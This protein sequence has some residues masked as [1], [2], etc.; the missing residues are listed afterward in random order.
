MNSRT[1]LITIIAVLLIVFCV[2]VY[3]LFFGG[4]AATSVVMPGGATGSLPNT[5][6]QSVSNSGS[7][8]STAS[9]NSTSAGAN[10]EVAINQP[11]I[12]YFASA[13]GT[14]T[15]VEPD[16]KIIQVVAGEQTVAVSSIAMQNVI[17]ASFS[18]NG[19]KVLVSFGDPADPQASVFDIRTKA[20]TPLP[21]GMLSP[22]WSPSDYRVAYTAAN[23][24]QG[25]ETIGTVNAAAVKPAATPLVTFHMQDLALAWPAK[26][27]LVLETKP[28]AYVAGSVWTINPASASTAAS[29]LTQ[30]ASEVPGLDMIW[31]GATIA[32]TAPEELEFASGGASM[33]GSLSLINT[34]GNTLQN[35]KMVTLPSKCLFASQIATTT[36]VATT[37]SST[38]R[39][40]ATSTPYLFCGVPRDQS[41]LS[42]SHLPDDYNQMS[43]FTADDIYQINLESGA[44]STIFDND[45]D[46]FDTSDVKYFDNALFFINRY[47]QKLYTI[48][49]MTM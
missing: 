14:I 10:V 28:S 42:Y 35:L 18:Y 27:Q 9:S 3:F 45:A 20:W 36:V 33:G 38:A 16:G 46:S 2:G 40:V 22:V 24:A 5:G 4:K 41:T 48:G 12:D 23:A 19:A 29:A 31:S 8:S 1:A 25:T 49:L 21:S 11:I 32:P 47:D 39:V 6:T 26:T 13:S 37:P 34:S 43:L 7:S 30:I 44:I 17:A 15:A